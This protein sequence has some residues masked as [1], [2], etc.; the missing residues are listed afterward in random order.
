MSAQIKYFGSHTILGMH[1]HSQGETPNWAELLW[2]LREKL[3]KHWGLAH[4]RQLRG[5][6]GRGES[7]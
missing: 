4:M 6:C 7:T 5:A 3:H 1:R 2:L